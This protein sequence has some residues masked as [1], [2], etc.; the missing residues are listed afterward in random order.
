MCRVATRWLMENHGFVRAG[1][2]AAVHEGDVRTTVSFE[3]TR[4]SSSSDM[5]FYVPVSFGLAVLDPVEP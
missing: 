5:R 4:W 2:W 1:R 3:K